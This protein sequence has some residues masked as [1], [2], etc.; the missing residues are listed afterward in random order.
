MRPILLLLL[1]AIFSYPV[2]DTF[3]VRDPACKLAD[4]DCFVCKIIPAG[5]RGA[6][7]Y[8][9]PSTGEAQ[10]LGVIR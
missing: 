2:S 5:W 4:G 9:F 10:F 3:G 8:Y 7:Y 6:A 1:L